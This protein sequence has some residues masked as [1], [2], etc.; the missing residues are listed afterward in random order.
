MG[1]LDFDAGSYRDPGSRVLDHDGRVLRTLDTA[2]AAE[3]A[4]LEQAGFLER[5]IRERWIVATRRADDLR[6]V[7]RETGSA[8]LLEHERVPFVS[9]PYEWTFSA[10]ERA[11]RHQLDLHRL[12]LAAGATLSDASAYNIQFVDTTPVFIDVASLRRYHDGEY[13]LAHQQFLNQFLNPL[14]STALCGL[15]FQRLYRGS[16][17]GLPSTA[18]LRMLPLRHRLRPGVFM[19]AVAPALFQRSAEGKVA[20]DAAGAVAQ[21]PF[22]KAAYLAMLN[23]LARLVASLRHSRAR[24]AAWADYESTNTYSQA[25]FEAKRAFVSAYAQATRPRMLLD[26][27]CNTGLYSEIAL[28]AG[29]SR[30]VGAEQE[31][32]TADLA[33]QRAERSG[34]RLLPLVID[35]ADPSPAQ[36]WRGAERRSFFARAR[37]DGMLA[38]AVEH[39]LAIGRNIPL[40]QL[41]DV[42][43]GL[44]PHGVVEFVPKRD[45]QVQR[46]LRLREDV[47]SE[48]SEAAFASLLAAR[49]RI[50]RQQ[51]ITATGRRLFWYERDRVR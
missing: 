46:L 20:S 21:R 5:L 22:P 29:A 47:F 23:G 50:V 51:T 42:L 31:P 39:H 11:A 2:A 1:A 19:H 18:L 32:A 36:G 15:D 28:A 14:L 9:Y 35:A 41:L 49:S 44:A 17:E 6:E 33:F 45:P 12:A 13:W 34:L 26:L 40:D 8:A 48:Y 3:F 30:V 7:R 38:L 4:W 16:L 43:V 24:G 25:E 27:G 37:F 10:L